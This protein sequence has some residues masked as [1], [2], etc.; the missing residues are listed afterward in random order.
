[1][2]QGEKNA[3]S[4]ENDDS[5][6]PVG[7]DVNANAEDKQ[8][9]SSDSAHVHMDK[10]SPRIDSTVR[11]INGESAMTLD[12]GGD[13]R[14]E[15]HEWACQPPDMDEKGIKNSR[16]K[17]RGIGEE[18]REHD[19]KDKSAEEDEADCNFDESANEEARLDLLSASVRDQDELERMVGRQV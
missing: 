15:S 11:D 12:G 14:G 3:G 8:F 4:T 7:E 18:E 13:S 2:S 9:Q 6:G 1:M 16:N 19:S 17:E 10:I 5:V